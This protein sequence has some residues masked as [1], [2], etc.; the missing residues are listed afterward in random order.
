[1][2]ERFKTTVIYL[3]T[4][5]YDEDMILETIYMKNMYNGLATF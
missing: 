2:C 4:P 3:S 1:M 5:A